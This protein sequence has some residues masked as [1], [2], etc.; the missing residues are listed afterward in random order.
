MQEYD[1]KSVHQKRSELLKL[2]LRNQQHPVTSDSL[3]LNEYPLSFS[4]QQLM[5]LDE[6]SSTLAYHESFVLNIEMNTDVRLMEQSINL[7][8]KRHEALRTRISSKTEYKQIILDH[9]EISLSE[10]TVQDDN[11]EEIVQYIQQ[12]FDL[13]SA[14]LFRAALLKGPGEWRLLFVFHHIICDGWSNAIFFNELYETY[15]SLLTGTAMVLPP[16]PA[17]YGQYC[18]IQ[19]RKLLNGEFKDSIQRF[20][21]TFKDFE[22]LR[23]P[24]D[25]MRSKSLKPKSGGANFT[26]Q[27]NKLE[28]LRR[29]SAAQGTTL[30]NSM[31]TAFVILL[32]RYTYQDDI[33]VGTAFANRVNQDFQKVFGYFAN[34]LPLRFR[35]HEEAATV[36]DLLEQVRRNLLEIQSFQSVPFES[37]VEK[38]N[39]NRQ[40]NLNPIFQIMFNYN[41]TLSLFDDSKDHW[42]VTRLDNGYAKMDMIFDITENDKDLELAIEY[43]SDMYN[44]ATIHSMIR[45][46]YHLLDQMVLYPQN[47]IGQLSLIDEASFNTLTSEWSRTEELA[48]P[49]HIME[50]F[51][52]TSSRYPERVAALFEDC[53]IT[54]RELDNQSNQVARLLRERGAGSNTLV[55]LCMQR[56]LGLLINLI[57]IIKSGGT[58]VP[59]D[60]TFPEKRIEQIIKHSGLKYVVADTETA[61]LPALTG[62]ELIIPAEDKKLFSNLPVDELSSQSE[63]IAYVIYTSGSTGAPKGVMITHENLINTLISVSKVIGISDEDVMVASSTIVFDISLLELLAPLIKGASVLILGKNAVFENELIGK[64]N[65]YSLKS[66]IAEHNATI[67]QSTPSMMKILLEQHLIKD[68]NLKT[69]LLGGE[70]VE[71][72]LVKEIYSAGFQGDIYNMYGPT[73]TTIW[74]SVHKVNPDLQDVSSGAV[75]IG[76]PIANTN[77]YVLDKYDQPVPVGVTGSLYIGGKSVSRGYL[78]QEELT[79]AKFRQDPFHEGIM[80]ETGDRARWMNDGTLQFMGREDRQVKWHGYRIQLDEIEEVLNEHPGIKES[81]VVLR[82]DIQ[83]EPVL[84]A[85]AVADISEQAIR[86]HLSVL[87]PAYSV[88]SIIMLLK[89]LPLTPNLKVDKK[90]LPRPDESAG[91]DVNES[92]KLHE[93]QAIILSGLWSEITGTRGYTQ[94]S[95]YFEVGGNSLNA[96]QLIRRIQEVFHVDVTLMDIFDHPLL[97]QISGVVSELIAKGEDQ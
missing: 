17:Q 3:Q 9:L 60:P 91:I 73:E 72:G 59:I 5:I 35:I 2:L 39:P 88:P 1:Q 84:V 66:M 34:S 18:E 22:L 90:R 21:H 6:M 85:Y 36:L 43:N 10:F 74:S 33:V 8:V 69:I 12:P 76:R 24:S 40:S 19:R 70:L 38:I 53:S 48:V 67:L 50:C 56:S 75:P 79:Q 44:S 65:Q 57:G 77:M 13:S 7:L 42:K 80:Y 83:Q 87:L 93:E 4:Q 51:K 54:Y 94:K 15:Q 89:E 64:E 61:L 86:S 55:G 32:H 45:D 29:F 52:V 14:P 78:N 92:F 63:S 26:I 16:L 58:F 49:Q 23:L 20:E 82:D 97:E 25:H 71:T 81:I 62:T 41:N 95:H 37:I 96:L 47:Q 68:I 11:C 46:Y 28:D 27:Q 30:F 31:L